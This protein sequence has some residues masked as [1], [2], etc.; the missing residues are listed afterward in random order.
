MS[1]RLKS[2]A[3]PGRASVKT[4]SM[5]KPDW[6]VLERTLTLA[7][8]FVASLPERS[9]APRMGGE[10]MLAAFDE[11][12]PDEPTDAMAVIERLARDA[13]PGLTAIPSGRFFD[14]VMGGGLPAA[15]AADWLTSVWDQNAGSVEG[16]PAG[17]VVERV[18]VRW[19]LELLD[20]P[21]HA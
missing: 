8:G 4:G 9:V 1:S 3:P 17:A 11:R 12:L 15:A 5:I 2:L 14:W 7:Q 10:A 20:L 18:A 19:M 13:D 21:R 16:T 6:R